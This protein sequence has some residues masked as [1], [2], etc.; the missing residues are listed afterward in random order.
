MMTISRCL[1]ESSLPS[2][3]E[4]ALT[5]ARAAAS[6]GSSRASHSAQGYP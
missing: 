6:G 5:G 4:S 3:N 2:P 1:I